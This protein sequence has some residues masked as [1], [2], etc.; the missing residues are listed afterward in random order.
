MTNSQ[1]LQYGNGTCGVVTITQEADIA[2]ARI[3]ILRN[4]GLI[5]TVP[6]PALD[7]DPDFL[8]FEYHQSNN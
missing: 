1:L 3:V 2:L 4:G 6:A 5:E 8:K 7:L